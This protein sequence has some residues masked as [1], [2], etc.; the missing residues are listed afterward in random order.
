MFC[1]IYDKNSEIPYFKHPKFKKTISQPKHLK[2]DLI[3]I[4]SHIIKTVKSTST[5]KQHLN[6]SNISVRISMHL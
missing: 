4:S 1:I 5:D 3:S 2:Y 6:R